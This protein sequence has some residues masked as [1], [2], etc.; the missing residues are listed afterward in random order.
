MLEITNKKSNRVH[1]MSSSE[2]LNFFRVNDINNY[3]IIDLKEKAN[4]KRNRMLDIAAGV[5]LIVAAMLMTILYV[6][7]NY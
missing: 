2:A 1:L 4:Q 6:N 7:T 5:G 3:T